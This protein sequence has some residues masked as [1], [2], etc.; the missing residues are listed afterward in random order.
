MEID[1][2]HILSTYLKK[3]SYQDN[4]LSLSYSYFTRLGYSRNIVDMRINAPQYMVND[5]L[6][7]V[8]HKAKDMFA[9]ADASMEQVTIQL[10]NEAEVKRKLHMFIGKIL[11]EFNSNKRTHGR[12][13]MISNRSMDFYY[14]DFE[15]DPLPDETKFYVHLNRGANKMNG[16]LWSAAIDD[17]KIALTFREDDPLANKY[18]A[19]ALLK[20]NRV[21]EAI[22]YYKK[23]VK[24]DKNLKSLNELAQAYIKIEDFKNAEKIYKQMQKLAPEDLLARIGH[25]QISYMQGKPYLDQL[26]E[27]F[28]LND[29]WLLEYLKKGWVYK[30]PGFGDDET[31]MWNAAAAARYLGY[32]RPFDLTKR[33]FNNEIPCYFDQEKGTIRFVKAELDSWIDIQNKFHIDGV[34]YKV[35]NDR[36]SDKEKEIGAIQMRPAKKSTKKAKKEKKA[37]KEAVA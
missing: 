12:V 6:S 34:D 24:S 10:L 21:E 4:R 22:P 5:F 17:L 14:N 7:N 25:A 2:L 26:E 19:Q 8:V 20:S 29:E 9:K 37:P 33:A 30:L 31:K 36:L 35:Y 28:E 23:Y 11:K 16:D 32:E 27:L 18:M 13:R 15:Y 1:E 3:W